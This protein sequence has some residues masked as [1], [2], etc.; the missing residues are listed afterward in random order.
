MSYN[1][2]KVISQT[3]RYCGGLIGES[4][5]TATGCYLLEGCCEYLGQSV[6]T[7]NNSIL[8][9]AQ[10]RSISSFNRWGSTTTIRQYWTPC[11]NSTYPRLLR[12]ER[13]SL[14]YDGNGNTEGE[15][16]LGN[17]YNAGDHAVID[18]AGTLGIDGR[19]LLGWNTEPDGSGTA[20]DIG[21]TVYIYENLTLYAQW[22][23]LG[24]DDHRFTA[25]SLTLKSRVGLNFFVDVSDLDPSNVRAV[26][27]WGDGNTETVALSGLTPEPAGQ[28]YA[29]LYK[30]T[31]HVAAKEMTDVV[32][33]TLY[34][35]E[36]VVGIGQYSVR[37]YA[38]RVY[39]NAGGE[40]D[41]LFDGEDKAER[42]E[43]LRV[44]CLRL[45]SY[46]CHA[47][48]HFDYHTERPATEGIAYIMAA[49]PRD[50]LGSYG[51]ADLTPF[52]I[53]FIGSSLILEA[54]TTHRLYFT[55]D[56]GL[57]AAALN[58]AV[59]VRC[60]SKVLRFTDGSSD[61]AGLVYVDIPDIAAQ[62]VLKNYTVR[63]SMDSFET[64]TPLKVN[65]GAYI[66]AALD[67]SWSNLFGIVTSLYWYS[68]AAEAYFGS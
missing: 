5:G 32:T 58:A 61:K 68:T 8:T 52:G 66:R 47:Q 33:A 35:G 26:F 62:N 9:D 28:S 45:L 42:L 56:P 46:G 22:S 12:Q 31:A 27:T 49:V 11:T 18:D 19:I 53:A 54:A 34:D 59:Q 48:E 14:T 38:K 24:W 1:T 41:D 60:G 65:A 55:P 20:Y 25:Y 64:S 6:G 13:Y 40:F 57:D 63:F 17:L 7:A 50:T 36:T 29:G 3:V 4:T 39:D 43:A 44:L 2:G 21:D 10:F 16:P 37:Q 30:I 23:P 51:S 15:A 67:D